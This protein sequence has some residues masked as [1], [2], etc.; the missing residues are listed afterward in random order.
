ML[1]QKILMKTLCVLL[2]HLEGVLVLVL[3]RKAWETELFRK[4]SI[5][6]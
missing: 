6:Y 3:K 4:F 5:L 2:R 1:W